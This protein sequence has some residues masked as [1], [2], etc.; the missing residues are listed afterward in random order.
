MNVAS[1]N[2]LVNENKNR[3][4]PWYYSMQGTWWYGKT[5][6]EARNVLME[7]E[8]DKKIAIASIIRNEEHTGNLGRFLGC[9]TELEQYHNNITYIFVEGDS[10]DGT[11]QILKDWISTRDGV[12]EKRDRGFSPFPKDTNP[13]RTTVF[14]ELRNRLVDLVLSKPNIAEVLMID[15]SYGWKGDL[16][17]A[18]REINADIAAPLNV[19]HK[20][21]DGRYVFYD[22]WAYRK[23]G[24]CFGPFYHYCEG[25]NDNAPIDIDSCGGAY[26]V[27]RSVFEAGVRYDGH[28]DCEHVSFCRD[29]KIKG[30]SIKMNPKVY[31]RK[32]GY[33][34]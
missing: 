1:F 2:K 6:D 32:G 12:L 31:V 4:R 21:A 23:S 29:A 17:T 5:E 18:L 30:S 19:C 27:K 7:K 3:N 8:K 22:I 16:I 26:L 20:N 28:A 15:A 9:C 13:V 11:Y 34:E 25:F 10:S 33:K 14:G 24:A